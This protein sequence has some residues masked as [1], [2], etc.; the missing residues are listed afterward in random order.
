VAPVE[1]EMGCL[2]LLD[3]IDDCEIRESFDDYLDDSFIP[4]QADLYNETW[5]CL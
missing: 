5:S 4:N 3:L 1:Q 2:S